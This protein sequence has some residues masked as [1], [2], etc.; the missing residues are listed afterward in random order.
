MIK[1]I[2]SPQYHPLSQCRTQIQQLNSNNSRIVYSIRNPILSLANDEFYKNT[3]WGTPTIFFNNL[4]SKINL[5]LP[6]QEIGWQLK[7]IVGPHVKFPM[8]QHKY[9]F[10]PQTQNGKQLSIHLQNLTGVKDRGVSI[11]K[12]HSFKSIPSIY[13]AARDDIQYVTKPN[14][15]SK[16]WIN[17]IR[18][19]TD[20]SVEE[21][22]GGSGVVISSMDDYIELG[23]TY[24]FPVTI[25]DCEMLAIKLALQTVGHCVRRLHTKIHICS[26]CEVAIKLLSQEYYPKWGSS[27]QLI[28][29]IHQL[30]RQILYNTSIKEIQIKKVP[31]HQG[32]ALNER[33]DQLANKYR[34]AATWPEAAA[35]LWTARSS[36]SYIKRKTKSLWEETYERNCTEYQKHNPLNFNYFRSFVKAPTTKFKNY[37][38]NLIVHRRT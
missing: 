28:L 35:N 9:T 37:S 16:E 23:E 25:L 21:M 17:L 7:E 32:I 10:S 30:L 31:A 36:L 13:I 22:T 26:D 11:S 19:F 15:P 5:T 3:H 14:K 20:G 27:Q 1:A 2:N 18:I 29:E 4:L 33:A 24:N 34:L 38:P 8:A 12:N 6:Q